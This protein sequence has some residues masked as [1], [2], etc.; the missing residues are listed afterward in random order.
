MD[1]RD[2]GGMGDGRTD[3]PSYR[4][5][6]THLKRK[7]LKRK[8]VVDIA[9]VF[10]RGV[11]ILHNFFSDTVTA[12]KRWKYERNLYKSEENWRHI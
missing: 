2:F 7:N 11:V 10:C 8:K 4:D 1:K 6:R 12:E 3:E 9:V 5:A